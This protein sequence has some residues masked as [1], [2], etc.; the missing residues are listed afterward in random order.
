MS[1]IKISDA[2][3]NIEKELQNNG[4]CVLRFLGGFHNKHT[5]KTRSPR[6]KDSANFKGCIYLHHHVDYARTYSAFLKLL[7]GLAIDTE[8]I[9]IHFS[10]S[11]R[12]Q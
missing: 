4:V 5:G 8:E 9:D 10:N 3:Q 11:S 7:R 2:L 12:T 1:E 6:T